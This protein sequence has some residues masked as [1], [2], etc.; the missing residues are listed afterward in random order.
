MIIS[1]Q[2]KMYNKNSQIFSK[3]TI[4]IMRKQKT[5]YNKVQI[6]Y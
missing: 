3:Y 5:N 6:F 2:K 4:S 1:E